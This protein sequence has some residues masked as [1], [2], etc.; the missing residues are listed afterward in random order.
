MYE[1]RAQVGSSSTRATAKSVKHHLEQG[2]WDTKQKAA[3]QILEPP[4]PVRREAV[5]ASAPE[6]HERRDH[7][8]RDGVVPPLLISCRRHKCFGSSLHN[9]AGRAGF[10][11]ALPRNA[12]QRTQAPAHMWAQAG[13]C[14]REA[15]STLKNQVFSSAKRVFSPLPFLPNRLVFC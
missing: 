12:P 3:F 4:V 11:V 14:T 6:R 2:E 5:P 10:A 7:A 13:A 9:L 8:T 1:A 15:L